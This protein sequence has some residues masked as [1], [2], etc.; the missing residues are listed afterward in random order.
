MKPPPYLSR[1][2]KQSKATR[3]AET[4]GGVGGERSEVFTERNE[5]THPDTGT[6]HEGNEVPA[7]TRAR[8]AE[9]GAQK[10]GAGGESKPRTARKGFPEDFARAAQ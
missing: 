3:K 9:P 1:Y 4:R 7:T 10:S 6:N 2:L 5:Q 8:G